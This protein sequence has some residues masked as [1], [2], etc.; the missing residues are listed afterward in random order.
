MRTI[1]SLI[2]L[3]VVIGVVVVA[4]QVSSSPCDRP[5]VLDERH[6]NITAGLEGT[7]FGSDNNVRLYLA[8]DVA[9]WLPR[10][11]QN[12]FQGEMSFG[13]YISG[14]VCRPTAI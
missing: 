10:L 1:L 5:A 11:I 2:L 14:T 3:Y 12:V 8:Q 9:L 7:V 4:I 13:D 6:F